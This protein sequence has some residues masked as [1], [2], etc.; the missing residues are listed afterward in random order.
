MGSFMLL[1]EVKKIHQQ[2]C[3]I[4]LPYR[5]C[6]NAPQVSESMQMV[7]RSSTMQKVKCFSQ[8]LITNNPKKFLY[9]VVKVLAP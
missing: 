6:Q 8:R 7:S 3:H 4:H 2:P 1:Q 5:H 9:N